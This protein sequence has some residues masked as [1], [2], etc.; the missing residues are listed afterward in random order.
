[1]DISGVQWL[2]QKLASCKL[3]K[4]SMQNLRMQNLSFFHDS[5]T[6][7]QEV[8]VPCPTG[9]LHIFASRGRSLRNNPENQ[10]S[11]NKFLR[12][13]F[14]FVYASIVKYVKT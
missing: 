12:V 13:K 10:N 1:V 8:K 11:E 5:L 7:F 6:H 14:L 3:E 4:D 9:F 2:H